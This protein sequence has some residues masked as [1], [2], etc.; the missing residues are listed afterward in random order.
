[1]SSIDDES[2]GTSGTAA[3]ESPSRPRRRRRKRVL[4]GVVIVV[5]IAVIAASLISVPYYALTPGTAQ[6]IA[7]LIIVPSSFNHGHAGS[8]DLVDVEVTPMRLIDF[9]WFKLQSNASI[10]SSAEIQGT[11][12]NAQYDTEGVLDME[13]AQQAAEVV[14]FAQ[15]GYHVTVTPNGALLYD[16]IPGSP[17]DEQLQVGDVVTS[18]DTFKITGPNNLVTA[19]AG[20]IPGEA[21]AVG[22]RSYPTG[23]ARHVSLRLGVWRLQGK[24]PNQQ[25]VCSPTSVR[26]PYPI[27]ELIETSGGI[28]LGT[29]QHPGHP[30]A[31]LG[32]VG[33]EASYAIS[34]LPFAVNLNSEGIV[35]PSAGLAF[36]LGLMQ[37]LDAA[38][39]TAGLQVAA[40][41][42]MSVT[43]AVG[44]IGGIQQKTAAVRSAGAS[45]FLV[46]AANYETAKQYAG[47][48]LKVFSVAS[49]AQALAVLKR[50]GGKIERP[51]GP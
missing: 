1:M 30:T 51:S 33:P 4:G 25:L 48:K 50:F 45:I 18:I 26:S 40:T 37:K 36:T 6:T 15:L 19:L 35:G 32:V 34:K 44:A 5:A 14:A 28:A 29:K 8:V 31:C 24:A 22:Y 3:E 49:I 17:A 47:T 39:L 7:P 11:E 12:T 2:L 42:T 41:G 20:R 16:I 46:P 27:A 43:G 21:I 10:I 9:L 23:A 13:D 38:N